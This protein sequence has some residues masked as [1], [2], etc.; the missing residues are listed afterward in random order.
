MR[1]NPGGTIGV[2]D[3]VG[4][5]ALVRDL[6]KSLEVQSLVLTSERRIGKTCVIRK[7]KD[8]CPDASTVCLLRDLEG[9]HS[10]Q[11]FVEAIYNDVES[12]LPAADRAS[13]KFQRLLSKLG[14]FEVHQ[15]KIPQIIPHWKGLLF[16]LFEDIFDNNERKVVFFWDELPLFIYN[17]SKASGEKVA[18]EVLDALRALRQSHDRL[19][20]VFTGSIG[21]HLVIQALRRE[22]YPNDPTNDMKLVEVCPLDGPDGPALALRLI[23][24]ENIQSDDRNALA[25]AVSEA[26]GRIPY[27]I[28]WLV[29]RMATS[30]QPV[31]GSDVQQHLESLICDAN[32]PAHFRYYRERLDVYYCSE[33]RAIA[34][35]ALD[36]MA[37]SDEAQS[38]ED[39]LNLIRHALPHAGE[40]P[41]RDT[42]HLLSKDHYIVR[43]AGARRFGFRYAIVRQWW[44]FE[45]R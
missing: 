28:H 1:A 26:A 15:L 36:V 31:S 44:R 29:A 30:R 7:M 11:E 37:D 33:E 4:R 38:F 45:R 27:Y 13:L 35:A 6:W 8:E 40:E 41:V 10:A 14:G 2:D 19:R 3:I 9:L 43:E 42:L 25:A 16:A 34:V 32:D 12:L 23:E 18:M 21:L 24:G 5:D 22:N 20:M 17:V 39:L